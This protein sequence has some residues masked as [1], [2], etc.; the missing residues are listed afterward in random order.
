MDVS[1][2]LKGETRRKKRNETSDHTFPFI[3][4]FS[5]Q[6][7][8][9]KTMWT[10]QKWANNNKDTEYLFEIESEQKRPIIV[11]NG[12]F[13]WFYFSVISSVSWPLKVAFFSLS[14]S[15]HKNYSTSLQ[16]LSGW[17]NCSGKKDHSA[18]IYNSLININKQ[19]SVTKTINH[20][21]PQQ[22]KKDNKLTF[23][24][25]NLSFSLSM[26]NGKNRFFFVVVDEIQ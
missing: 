6:F 21:P 26:Q 4:I 17:C 19:E 8:R 10:E 25:N 1:Y 23:W 15:T 13:L 24:W 14:L 2:L 18:F 20:H 22:K 9:K 3:F 12:I 5:I 11:I 7:L 16:L